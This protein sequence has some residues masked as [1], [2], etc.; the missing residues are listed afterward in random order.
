MKS[1][2][3]FSLAIA[4]QPLW[5]VTSGVQMSDSLTWTGGVQRETDGDN[6][7]HSIIFLNVPQKAKFS[8]TQTHQ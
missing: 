1:E 2:S 5:V 7:R 8:E 6:S 4:S 3:D